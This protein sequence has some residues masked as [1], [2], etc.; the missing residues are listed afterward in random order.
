MRQLSVALALIPMLVAGCDRPPAKPVT[1]ATAAGASVSAPDELAGLRQR[2]AQLEEENAALRETPAVM[3]SAV[4]GAGDDVDKAKTAAQRLEQRYPDARE[5]KD[6]AQLVAAVEKRAE[7]AALEA[8]RL[9]ALGLKALRVQSA[10]EGDSATVA[11]SAVGQGKRWTFDRYD[12]TYHYR[13]AEKGSVFI[14]AQAKVSSKSKDPTLPGI[15][16]YVGEGATMQKVNDFSY[17]FR[18]W[19][20]FATYLG[21]HSD[22]PNDFAH[23]SVIPMTIGVEVE[24][25]KLARPFFIVATKQGCEGRNFD[26]FTQPPVSYSR[27]GCDSLKPALEVGD[28]DSGSLIVL[29]RFD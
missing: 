3:L 2:I 1:A 24:T 16:L 4:Q 21:N 13:D 7:K 5:S 18:R 25:G 10:V 9:A 26:R 20:G 19:D 14:H 15:A 8:K 23:A 27:S 22:Y 28:F 12:D 11:L 29:H 17:R 6:A